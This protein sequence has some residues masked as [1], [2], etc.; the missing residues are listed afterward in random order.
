MATLRIDIDDTSMV[1]DARLKTLDDVLNAM[2]SEA[3]K[4]VDEAWKDGANRFG[5]N[6]QK[7]W[8]H[9]DM[10]DN[11]EAQPGKRKTSSYRSVQIYPRRS[12]T[13]LYNNGKSQT[14]TNAQKAFYL[15]YGTTVRG[16]TH[17]LG[18]KWVELVR[19]WSDPEAIAAMERIWEKYNNQ[20]S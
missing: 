10:H 12:I 11:V 9:G 2:L 16:K 13:R 7:D 19:Q 3:G 17:V 15:N 8:S 1:I 5:H 6:K 20:N 14:I 18:D 4:L